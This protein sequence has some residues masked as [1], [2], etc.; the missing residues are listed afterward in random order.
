MAPP[1][2]FWRFLTHERAR[3]ILKS[4]PNTEPYT[5][6]INKRILTG[7][8]YKALMETRRLTAVEKEPLA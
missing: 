2:S 7:E 5:E 1:F 4:A 6:L 8:L 3:E